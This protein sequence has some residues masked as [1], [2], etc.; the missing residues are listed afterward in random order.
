MMFIAMV[1]DLN[2]RYSAA[3]TLFSLERLTNRGSQLER[4]ARAATRHF[5]V[6]TYPTLARGMEHV[7][8]WLA[9]QA[10]SSEE[11]AQ[12]IMRGNFAN[13][14]SVDAGY[15]GAGVTPCTCDSCA[16]EACSPPLGVDVG[17]SVVSALSA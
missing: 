14:S 6:G 15:F 7:K 3:P 5:F 13:L 16:V 1:T 11:V 4:E 2:T 12:S 17:I 8:V 9:F 10:T